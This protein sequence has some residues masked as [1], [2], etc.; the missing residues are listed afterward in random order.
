MPSAAKFWTYN[1]GSHAGSGVAADWF[2]V[3]LATARRLYPSWRALNGGQQPKRHETVWRT[4]AIGKGRRDNK[5]RDLAAVLEGLPRAPRLNDE[6]SL[7]R[8]VC[9]RDTSA[10]SRPVSSADAI[11]FTIPVATASRAGTCR[12]WNRRVCVSPGSSVPVP[13]SDRGLGQ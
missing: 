13:W 11:G 7:P 3:P 8:W 1:S 4:V 6:R 12:N 2:P 5:W 9:S 10:G